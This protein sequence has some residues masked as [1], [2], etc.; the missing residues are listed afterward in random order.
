MHL[1]P[2]YRSTDQVQALPILRI[3]HAED[4][5]M[6]HF[7]DDYPP[8][9]VSIDFIE[10]YQVQTGGYWVVYPGLITGYLSKEEFEEKYERV[11]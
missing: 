7:D 2:L 11:E 3:E 6:L 4:G 1:L 8:V 9:K 5:V 10:N